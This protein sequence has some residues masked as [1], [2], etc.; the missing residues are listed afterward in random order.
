MMEHGMRMLLHW[1]DRNSMAHSIESRVPF[2]D[3]RLMPL[4]FSLS[5]SQRVG[6]GWSKS[7][8][9]KSMRGLLPPPVIFRKDKMGFVTPESLWARNECS[10]LYLNEMRELHEEWG[11]LIGPRIIKSF[12]QFLRKERNYDSLFWKLVCLNRWRKTFNVRL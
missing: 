9:R 6:E 4:L 5:D 1:E 8:I 7:V 2:L 12:E 3:Y 10:E 11:E